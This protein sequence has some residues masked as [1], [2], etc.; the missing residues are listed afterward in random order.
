MKA[1][2]L[3]QPWATLVAIGEKRIETRS[4]STRYRGRIAIH[5][6]KAFPLG[7][8]ELCYDD[9]FHSAICGAGVGDGPWALPR[10]AIVATARL[11]D[12]LP[13]DAAPIAGRDCIAPDGEDPLI[14]VWHPMTL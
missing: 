12:C 3:T 6:A 1:I 11:V 8:Q 10:G 14:R 7:A 4:W 2:T 13:I 9:P 5:A